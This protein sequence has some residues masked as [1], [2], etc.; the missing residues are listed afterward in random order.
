MVNN[1]LFKCGTL[2]FAD[3]GSLEIQRAASIHQKASRACRSA[4]RSA[5]ANFRFE[6]L[7]HRGQVGLRLQPKFGTHVS[8]RLLQRAA[9]F[10]D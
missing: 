5:L 9:L 10:E 8:K 4:P 6:L 7:D 2:G 1:N 3:A